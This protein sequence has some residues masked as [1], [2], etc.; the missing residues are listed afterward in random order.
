M[1][2]RLHT[3]RCTHCM[4]P[5]ELCKP[6]VTPLGHALGGRGC[7]CRVRPRLNVAAAPGSS[8]AAWQCLPWPPHCP[9]TVSRQGLLVTTGLMGCIHAEESWKAAWLSGLKCKCT[10]EYFWKTRPLGAG[11]PLTCFHFGHSNLPMRLWMHLGSHLQGGLQALQHLQTASNS[12]VRLKSATAAGRQAAA[13]AQL[14]CH[15]RGQ[16]GPAAEAVAAGGVFAVWMPT[17]CRPYAC[18]S[19]LE[20]RYPHRACGRERPTTR[21]L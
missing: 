14:A 16:A 15:D 4:L 3:V 19:M 13:G 11:I 9:G 12:G 5:P 6:R 18:A 10:V 8:T 2:W 21:R 7:V 20:G 1:G 17:P